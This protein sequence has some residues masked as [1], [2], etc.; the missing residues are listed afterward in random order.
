MA[1]FAKTESASD[2]HENWA[3]RMAPAALRP[4]LTLIRVDRPIGTWL[5]LIPCW[6]GLTL[7]LAGPGRT[8][9]IAA[10]PEWAAGLVF[11]ALF[12]VGS[13]VMRGAG[14]V[15]NDIR[16]RELDARVARTADRPIASGEVGLKSGYLY[17]VLLSLVGLLV[18]L[19]FNRFTV[20]LA[21]ASLPLIALYPLMKRVTYWPQAWLGITF[22]WGALV[23]YAAVAG[24]LAYPALALY[25]AGI[26]WTLGYDTIYAHQDK[27]DDALVGIKSTALKLGGDSKRW[28][29]GFYILT[30]VGL[31]AAGWLAGLAWPFYVA[32]AAA[33]LQLGWQI[34]TIDFDDPANCLVKF[35]SN[36]WFGLLVLLGVVLGGT[37]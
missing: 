37:I 11:G 6:W 4:Y 36:K 14:C 3:H 29:Y 15:W 33:A 19:Q 34:E 13:F 23:G 16:D 32:L 26:V 25:A 28:L 22:N 20:A 18:L 35:K 5:L 27:E 2:I 1:G 24:T 21:I 9:E 10:A 12:A 17:M 31:G 8:P 30:V 7:A